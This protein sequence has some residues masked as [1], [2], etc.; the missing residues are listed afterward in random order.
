MHKIQNTPKIVTIIG[1]ALEGLAAFS[2]ILS[3]IFIPL[4]FNSE[5]FL[6][7]LGEMTS[8]ELEFFDI[9]ISWMTS[10]MIVFA[11]LFTIMFTINI[12]LFTKLIRGKFTEEQAKK[13][14]LYQA[15][16]GGISILLNT[17]TGILYLVSGVQGYSGHVDKID[18]REGI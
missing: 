12:I 10:I 16:W 5:F 13:V 8:E 17:V 2:A 6:S 9:M 1:L 4:L 18:T 11:L 15:I 7:D 14:Y 3:A